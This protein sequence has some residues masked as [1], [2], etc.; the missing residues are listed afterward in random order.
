MRIV[1]DTAALIPALR[2][3]TGAAAENVRL[4]LLRQLTILMD[5]T[6]A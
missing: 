2:S 3:S 6:L 5:Y 4:A 1:L